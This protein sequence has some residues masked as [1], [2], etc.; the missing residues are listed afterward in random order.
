[1]D[2]FSNILWAGRTGIVG[3]MLIFSAFTVSFGQEVEHNYLVGPSKT[4]CDSLRLDG[5]SFNEALET[6]ANTSFRFQQKFKYSRLSGVQ[7]GQFYSCDGKSG[8][9][10]LTVDK[11]TTIY[12]D[13]PKT[14]W[15]N[16]IQSSDPD[17]LYIEKIRD[18]FTGIAE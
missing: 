16:L 1:M 18:E 5:L 17:L 3:C 10:L 2:S 15:D 14:I 9:L 11:A 4:D 8:F 12:K 7:A 6:I 13:V